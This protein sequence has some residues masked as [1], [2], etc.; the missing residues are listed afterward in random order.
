MSI[1]FRLRQ[2]GL[3]VTLLERGVCGREASWAGAGIISP[4]DPH[5]TDTFYQIHCAS[6]DRYSSFAAELTELSGVDTEYNPCGGLDLLTTEQFVQMAKSDVRVDAAKPGPATLELLTREQARELEPAV[7][8]EC[9]AVLRCTRT[10]Q[11]R[12]PRLLEALHISCDRLGCTLREGVAVRSLIRTGDRITGVSCDDGTYAASFVVLA[13]GAWSSQ[14]G[15]VELARRVPVH[16]MRGQIVLVQTATP[17]FRHV[18]NK[19]RAYLVARRDGHVL[20]GATDEPDAGFE[21]RNTPAG[22]NWLIQQALSMVPSLSDASLVTQWAGL[23]P[24]TPDARPHIGPVP[25]YDGLIAACGH[26]RTGLTLAP[27]TADIV[28]DLIVSGS[29]PFDLSRCAPGRAAREIV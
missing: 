6:L 18:I 26:Y 22:V 10:A 23:R 1:A 12:N 24:G 5:R 15:D 20:I 14:L 16:P 8:G 11:V 27:V 9:L 29:S 13:A 21:K 3:T 25:G 2:A 17:P 7:T 19:R 28:R 4:A